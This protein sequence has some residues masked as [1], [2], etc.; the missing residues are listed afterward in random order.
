MVCGRMKSIY[1]K[2]RYGVFCVTGS[3]MKMGVLVESS[4]GSS[5][6]E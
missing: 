6:K 2:T 1:L 4:S 5:S 3:V